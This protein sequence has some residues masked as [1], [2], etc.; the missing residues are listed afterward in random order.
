MKPDNSYS[1]IQIRPVAVVKFTPSELHPH[2]D[3][4]DELYYPPEV[5][6]TP[7]QFSENFHLMHPSPSLNDELGILNE[8]IGTFKSGRKLKRKTAEFLDD[9][10]DQPQ[11]YQQESSTVSFPEYVK[12]VKQ[13]LRKVSGKENGDS[14]IDGGEEDME[15]LRN[16][17]KSINQVREPRVED[18]E[19]LFAQKYRKVNSI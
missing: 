4:A 19:K 12:A 6:E 18:Y 3:Y 5:G 2:G 8:E 17:L 15:F 7:R 10:F 11:L 14:N 16:N 9:N 1:N 13:I